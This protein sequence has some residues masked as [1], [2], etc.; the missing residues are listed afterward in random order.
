MAWMST[1]SLKTLAETDAEFQGDFSLRCDCDWFAV[2]FLSCAS[3]SKT[4]VEHAHNT[5]TNTQYTRTQT[6]THTH[7]QKRLNHSP[8]YTHT[9]LSCCRH[10]RVLSGMCW[11]TTTLCTST[12]P[13]SRPRVL[14]SSQTAVSASNRH[15]YFPVFQTKTKKYIFC[16]FPFLSSFMKEGLIVLLN[17]V[18]HCMVVHTCTVCLVSVHAYLFRICFKWL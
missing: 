2:W 17:T 13:I 10:H 16:S 12:F 11:Q 15:V 8:T 18:E 3:C 1:S 4:L 5:Y 7:A 9:T 14:C 6:H